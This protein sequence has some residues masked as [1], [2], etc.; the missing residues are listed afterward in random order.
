MKRLILV[1]VTDRYGKQIKALYYNSRR[2]AEITAAYLKD[3]YFDDV[4]IQVIDLTNYTTG[5]QK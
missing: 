3:Y 2:D 1:K 5:G 4:T